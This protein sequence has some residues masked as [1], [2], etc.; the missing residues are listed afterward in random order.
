MY[1]DHGMGWWGFAGMGV[2][3]V[4]F[5]A[6]ILTIVVAAVLATSDRATHSPPIVKSTSPQSILDARF[7]RGEIDA[8]EYRERTV[9]LEEGSD[10][11]RH[12]ERAL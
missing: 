4:L 7:A 8:T 11:R 9:I 10:T 2:G 3:V 6:L 5:C 12:D 1:Y